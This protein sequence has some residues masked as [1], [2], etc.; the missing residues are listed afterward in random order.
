MHSHVKRAS[1]TPS[2][3]RLCLALLGVILSLIALLTACGSEHAAT[4]NQQP[5]SLIGD[6]RQV[7]HNPDGWFTASITGGS[8]QVNL[9]GRDS[10]SIYWMGSFD[11]SHPTVGKFKI[12]SIPD[13][14]AR[15]TMKTSLMASEETTK[16]FTYDNGV[17]SFKYSILGTSAVIQLKQTKPHIP[18]LTKTVTPKVTKSKA[19]M[20]TPARKTTSAKSAAT[21]KATLTK[22]R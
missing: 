15:Y 14:D 7:G 20:R 8:I 9:E 13:A 17:I 4:A 22:K 11:S 12:V 16:P 18:T 10:S 2:V 19:A 21:K 6:W 3:I 5:K 1:I